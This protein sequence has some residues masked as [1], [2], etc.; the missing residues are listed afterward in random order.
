MSAPAATA[1]PDSD[2]VPRSVER[3]LDL[4]EIVVMA[5]PA[6]LTSIAAAADLT[7][8]TALRY[9]RALDARDYIV[10]DEDGRYAA[11]PTVARLAS[12]SG[13]SEV[14]DRLLIIAR[15]IL[16]GLAAVTGESAYLA[17]ADDDHATYVA[18][19][20]SPRAIRHVGWIGQQ[21]PLSGTAVGAALTHPATTQVRTGAVEPDITAI[22][23]AVAGTHPIAVAISIVGPEH[24]LRGASRRSSIA[25]LEDNVATVSERFHALVA[26]TASL[27]RV[28]S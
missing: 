8:T 27:P 5:G 1:G 4:L 2:S 23:R 21:I 18:R 16:E 25:A 9:L 28:T 6:N 12:N 22:S 10:R 14:L 24:R 26:S 15:P 17:V 19:A 7:P 3:L 13:T 11:G 20:E